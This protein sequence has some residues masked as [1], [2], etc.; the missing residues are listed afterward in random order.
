MILSDPEVES[1]IL[2]SSDEGA[3][4]EKYPISFHVLSLLFHPSQENWILAYSHDSK[5]AGTCVNLTSHLSL[6]SLSLSF[7]VM[8]A[9]MP[10]GNIFTP[11]SLPPQRIDGHHPNFI[12]QLYSSMDFGRK[13]QLV[14]DNVMPGRFYWYDY[15][16][17][18]LFLTFFL[19]A[20]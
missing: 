8:T 12:L 10:A 6:L 15:A 20:L 2:I 4:F 5:V 14:H 7:C 17:F 11:P 1:A 18:F 9:L 16:I 19:L 3:S 13:W